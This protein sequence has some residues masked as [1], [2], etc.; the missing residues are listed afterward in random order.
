MSERISNYEI[1]K[2]R[3]CQKFLKYDQEQM[4]RKFAL[5]FDD[6]YLYIRFIGH[7]YRISRSTGVL[8]WSQDGFQ[9]CIEGN[10]NEVLTIYDVLCDSKEGCH[11]AKDY[12]N[13]KSLSTLQASS[14]KLGEGLLDG[15]D[16][17][18]DHK[19][20]QLC[21][22]CEKLGGIKLEKGDVAYEIPVFD[23]LS[24]RIQFWNSDEDFEAILYIFMDKNILQFMKYETVWY[25]QAHLLD[26]LT[27]GLHELECRTKCE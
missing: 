18:F 14:K 10:F 2:R 9:T 25:V 17:I 8:E 15:K 4:I 19:E 5:K 26:R 13:L 27:E 7:S 16:R 22:I 6:E 20:K 21:E 24:C 23:F 3:V 12:V 11:A 1:T